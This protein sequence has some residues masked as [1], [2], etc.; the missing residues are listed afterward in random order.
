MPHGIAQYSSV[1]YIVSIEDRDNVVFPV[2]RIN[3]LERIV[4]F[5]G[6]GLACMLLWEW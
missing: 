1:T 6:F 3:I 5:D 4:R 2:E